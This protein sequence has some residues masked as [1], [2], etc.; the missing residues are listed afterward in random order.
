MALK[1]VLVRMEPGMFRALSP[2][3]FEGPPSTTVVHWDRDI[4][5]SELDPQ[6]MGKQSQGAGGL[7]SAS[8]G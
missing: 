5:G 6:G 7:L 8:I 4:S 2:C 1:E 3:L